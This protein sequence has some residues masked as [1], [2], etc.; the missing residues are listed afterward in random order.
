MLPAEDRDEREPLGVRGGSTRGG[1]LAVARSLAPIASAILL[2]LIAVL[3]GIIVR[4]GEQPSKTKPTDCNF[5][6]PI[7]PQPPFAP[8]TPVLLSKGLV[9]L[10]ADKGMQPNTDVLLVD[11]KISRV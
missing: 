11:G 2:A 6:V 1:A 4:Q 8:H 7:T 9:W 3:L 10:G 5:N